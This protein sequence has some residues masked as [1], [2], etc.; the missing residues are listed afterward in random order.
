M[1]LFSVPGL[2]FVNANPE[3]LVSSCFF[4]ISFCSLEV[5][6]DIPSSAGGPVRSRA[7][8]APAGRSLPLVHLRCMRR[9]HCERRLGRFLPTR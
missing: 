3:I 6:I 5:R 9:W 4:S 1:A 7:D 2:K 8:A